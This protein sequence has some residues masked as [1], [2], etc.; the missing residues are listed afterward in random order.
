MGSR[1]RRLI[2]R[3]GY[4]ERLYG[5]TASQNHGVERDGAHS[6]KSRMTHMFPRAP[7]RPLDW[8]MVRKWLTESPNS[9]HVGYGKRWRAQQHI[10][11]SVDDLEAS[12]PPR[13]P[14]SVHLGNWPT[15]GASS[16][17]CSLLDDHVPGL[18]P[19]LSCSKSHAT[20]VPTYQTLRIRVPTKGVTRWLSSVEYTEPGRE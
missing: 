17:F 7:A 4:R 15:P 3:G 16:C 14:N 12:S 5:A 9:R 8:R 11:V 20:L 19:N 18:R 6:N 1:T 2:G 10:H 13:F